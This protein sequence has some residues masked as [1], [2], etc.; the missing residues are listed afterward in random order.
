MLQ[1]KI[2][3]YF[4]KVTCEMCKKPVLKKETICFCC[5]LKKLEERRERKALKISGSECFRVWA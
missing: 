2:P 5:L 4:G 1:T 3:D